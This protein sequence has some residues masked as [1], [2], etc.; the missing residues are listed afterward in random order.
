MTR[1]LAAPKG[2]QSEALRF[3]L[4]CRSRCCS[5]FCVARPPAA[6]YVTMCVC[7]GTD[8]AVPVMC[9]EGPRLATAARSG[10]WWGGGLALWCVSVS[11]N[12]PNDLT[13][14]CQKRRAL[15][16]PARHSPH[17][18]LSPLCELST[19][20]LLFLSPPITHT[21][22]MDTHATVTPQA[23][24]PAT[25]PASAPSPPHGH[26]AA[27]AGNTRRAARL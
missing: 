22:T 24:A 11:N 7:L 12:I 14:L 6:V 9:C 10:V 19:Q 2:N 1:Q 8:R 15:S 16:P 25:A 3:R 21:R 20:Q 27:A 5:A 23:R 4:A 18:P 17:P 26:A 13:R